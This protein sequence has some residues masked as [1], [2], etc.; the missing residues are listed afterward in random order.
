MDTET[1]LP[2]LGISVHEIAERVYNLRLDL[3]LMM[4]LGFKS[5]LIQRQN[6][7]KNL[8]IC[9]T[10]HKSYGCLLMFREGKVTTVYIPI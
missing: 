10:Y 2:Y 3:I 1:Y 6:S 7:I 9:D 5:I 8:A 4:P